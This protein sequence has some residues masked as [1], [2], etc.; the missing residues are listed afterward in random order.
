MSKKIVFLLFI[1]FNHNIFAGG[2]SGADILNI[3]TG[4]RA[5]GLG[6][7]YTSAGDDVESIYYNP[8]GI[9]LIDK[10]EFFYMY[11][12]SYA[13]I[14]I[15]SFSFA[16]PIETVFLEGTAGVSIL[17]RTMPEIK[18]EDA[19]DSP[20][21]FSDMAFIITYANKLFYFIN[22]PDLKNFI[23]G[24]NIKFIME[25]L[26]Q[27]NVSAFAFDIGTKWNMP[28]SKLKIGVSLQNIGFPYKYINEESPMP[29]LIRIG[30]SFDVNLD[31]DNDLKF[32]LDYIHN[33]YDT[34]KVAIGLENNILNLFFLRAGYNVSLNTNTPSS[35]SLGAGIAITQFDINV[36]LNYVWKPIFWMGIS[37]FD[38]NHILSLQ[39]KF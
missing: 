25:T 38:S 28:D 13:D 27:Y 35:L 21:K 39:V 4:G 1:L 37:D 31:K 11:M 8:A 17:Y 5:L 15:N 29:F 19:K 16:Q 23:V 33:F 2:S 6:G 9:A 10:K 36:A 20:V 34:G 22:S 7:A 24:L 32:A 14:N 12:I 18:N 3:S 30:S 26:A